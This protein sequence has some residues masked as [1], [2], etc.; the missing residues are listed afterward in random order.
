MVF[1]MSATLIDQVDMRGDVLNVF[2]NYPGRRF[3]FSTLSNELDE[4]LECSHF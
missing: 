3:R 4:V 1:N 2:L